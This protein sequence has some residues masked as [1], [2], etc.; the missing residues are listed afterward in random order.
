MRRV[1]AALA[2]MFALV[3]LGAPAAAAPSKPVALQPGTF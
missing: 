2:V 1:I 3:V